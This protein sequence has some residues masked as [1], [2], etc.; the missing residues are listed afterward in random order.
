MWAMNG[1]AN[2]WLPRTTTLH[3]PNFR[4]ES[5]AGAVN[6]AAGTKTFTLSDASNTVGPYTFSIEAG[7]HTM[8][9]VF[10]GY[11]RM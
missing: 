4:G 5:I 3:H 11:P 2:A 1:G 6:L 9:I 10:P 8:L 7:T